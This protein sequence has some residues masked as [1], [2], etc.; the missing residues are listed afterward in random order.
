MYFLVEEQ[1]GMNGANIQIY[2]SIN[3]NNERNKT[4]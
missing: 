1:H 4:S 3:K 2:H